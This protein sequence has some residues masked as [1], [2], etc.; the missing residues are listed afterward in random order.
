MSAFPRDVE[1]EVIK[2]DWNEYKLS[3]GAI[4]KTK[5]TLGKIVI[6]PGYTLET[7]KG[8]NFQTQNMIVA[9]VPQNMKGTPIGRR[10]SPQEIEESI[11]EDLDFEQTKEAVN[12]YK[13]PNNIKIKLRLMLTRVAKTDKFAPDGTP[14]YATSTQIVPQIKFPKGFRRKPL[15][16][17]GKTPVV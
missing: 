2:E 4:L 8:F 15:R 1:F 7:T 12:E 14:I 3:D 10:L 13:L 17:K 6:P 9:Y 16:R 5:L 11:V